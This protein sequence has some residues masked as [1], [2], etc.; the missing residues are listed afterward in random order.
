VPNAKP[1]KKA[2]Q[3]RSTFCQQF[4]AVLCSLLS[5]SYIPFRKLITSLP[6]RSSAG[7]LTRPSTHHHHH[8]RE[9]QSFKTLFIKGRG[10]GIL[11]KKLTHLNHAHL[12]ALSQSPD[13][14]FSFKSI[15]L[16]LFHQVHMGDQSCHFGLKSSH[17]FECIIIF[18]SFFI[19]SYFMCMNFLPSGVCLF[20]SLY[21][22][23]PGKNREELLLHM[24][25]SVHLLLAKISMGHQIPWD[26]SYK[27]L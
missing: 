6:T 12:N 15:L 8:P 14:N 7:N 2:L 25:S 26:W 23:A 19:I 9:E 22:L 11:K 27:Q 10:G 4:S 5:K 13:R 21:P 20:T 3:A 17:C 16:Y 1:S 24:W 18:P